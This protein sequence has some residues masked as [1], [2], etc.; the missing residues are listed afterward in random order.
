[1]SVPDNVVPN[2]WFN[3]RLG[4]SSHQAQ[5]IANDF[6][7]SSRTSWVVPAGHYFMMGDN[8]DNSSDSRVPTVAGGVGFVPYE[9]IVGK[10]SRVVF[11]SAGSSMLYFWTWRSDRFFERIE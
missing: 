4:E 1:M 6:R 7:S 11:S 10:A 5:I 8:R 3:E 9:N 2:S